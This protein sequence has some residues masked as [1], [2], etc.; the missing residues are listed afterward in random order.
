MPDTPE[1]TDTDDR[2][3]AAAAY[4]QVARAAT[5][6]VPV[7]R[8]ARRASAVFA[9]AGILVWAIWFVPSRLAIWPVF[10]SVVALLL[11]AVPAGVY[12]FFA[13]ALQQLADVPWMLRNRAIEGGEHVASATAALRDTP[14]KGAPP[15]IRL[16]RSLYQLGRLG[17]D[18][19]GAV[20]GAV[21][22][23][24]LANPVTILAILIAGAAGLLYCAVAATGVLLAIL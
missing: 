20:L 7:V 13:A 1:L 19:K 8:F 2:S 24:R 15:I 22:V 4:E 17:I 21:G 9:L 14:S 18:T 3:I 10:G 12:A 23:V 11:L 16:L 5:L 6:A